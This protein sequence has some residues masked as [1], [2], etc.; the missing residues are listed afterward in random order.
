MS[1]GRASLQRYMDGLLAPLTAALN[2]LA[3]LPADQ[4]PADSLDA[5]ICALRAQQ[6][7][8]LPS[9]PLAALMGSTPTPTPLPRLV[10]Q[11]VS[12]GLISLD[13][14]PS[15]LSPRRPPDSP[16]MIRAHERQ[17]SVDSQPSDSE[18]A[19]LRSRSGKNAWQRMLLP[20]LKKRKAEINPWTKYE[21]HKQATELCQRWDYNAATA[22][23][24]TAPCLT[25]RTA[26]R[27]T[28]PHA[29]PLNHH[30][31][32]PPPHTHPIILESTV[33]GWWRRWE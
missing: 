17:Q 18:P 22:S 19:V 13:A 12:T 2:S 1:D 6:P 32:T 23:N 11:L 27:L 24:A 21:V 14:S 9:K 33:L 15:S 25:N 4:R 31:T 26:L 10:S 16:C 28:R 5:L 7:L 29:T 3:S 30:T 8:A 20:A